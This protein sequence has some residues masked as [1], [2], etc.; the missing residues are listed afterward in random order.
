MKRSAAQAT[1]DIR[2]E[3]HALQG[4]QPA[5]S[6]SQNAARQVARRAIG[7]SHELTLKLR[8]NYVGAEPFYS[9]TDGATL[10]AFHA[11]RAASDDT[12]GDGADARRVFGGAHPNT[13]G[14]VGEGQKR[15]PR[16]APR[17]TPDA[18]QSRSILRRKRAGLGRART[19]PRGLRLDGR[20]PQRVRR[21]P[22]VSSENVTTAAAAL[23]LRGPR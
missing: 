4:S 21:P 2:N 13:E 1:V 19:L 22:S 17:E 7:E 16:S 6:E 10:D 11:T 20:P 23:L 18:G 15:E 14:I 12:R 8:R 5:L 9:G 3:L